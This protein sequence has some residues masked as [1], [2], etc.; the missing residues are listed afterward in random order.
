[1]H[2]NPL[3]AL[4]GAGLLLTACTTTFEE[5]RIDYKSAS[6]QQA[7]SLAV[8]PDLTQ[9]P[10]QSRY[11]V[12]GG[13]VSARAL[14]A[15][16]PQA[17]PLE[18]TAATALGDVRMA[19]DGAQRWLVVQ[20]SPAQVWEAVRDFWLEHGFALA[21]EDRQIGILETDWA[22]NR[23]KL[24]QDLIR[25]TLGRVLD[26]LYSTGERDRFRTRL[27][28]TQDGGT[29]IYITHRGMQEVYTS[30]QQEH[31]VWQ[32]RA[33]DPELETEFLRRLMVRLGTSQE[34][35]DA[36][37]QSPSATSTASAHGSGV[38]VLSSDGTPLLRL[39]EG[40]DR[41]WRRVGLALDRSGFTVEDRDRSQGI[42]YVRYVPQNT[43]EEARGFFG[44]L[45]S[46]TPDAAAPQ[47]YQIQIRS[48]GAQSTVAVHNS[49][50][51]PEASA[52]AQRIVDLLAEDMR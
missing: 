39:D 38:H 9:L 45:F 51:Q 10:D 12:P 34:Q 20:R 28:S 16:S 43:Q 5:S 21:S 26:S 42:Y 15:G 31:T 14:Q 29:E 37:L 48:A 3:L 52:S 6:A 33:P 2:T 18:R 35:A 11:A 7:P 41:A 13:S 32:P 27:E 30:A 36:L 17:Q 47:R 1:M 8:P 4:L 46:R 19:R 44:R 49:Q 23:A 24:P 40:F 50:G 22:E 25:R